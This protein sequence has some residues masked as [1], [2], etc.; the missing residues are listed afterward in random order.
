MT[1]LALYV[2][3]EAM[4]GKVEEAAAFIRSVLPFVDEE[5]GTTA[6]L[7]L[8]AGPA[9]FAIFDA[10]PDEEARTVHPNG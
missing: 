9:S 3:R 5:E 7:E 1:K 2:P 10:F 8:Q 6:W 4:R